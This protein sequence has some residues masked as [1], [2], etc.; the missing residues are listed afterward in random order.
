MNRAAR[1]VGIILGCL[2]AATIIGYAYYKTKNLILGPTITITNPQNNAS[3]TESLVHLKGIIKN[4]TEVSVNNRKV[5]ISEKGELD[6]KLLLLPGYNII[7]INAK[8]RFGHSTSQTI[9]S[10]FVETKT[11]SSS[12]PL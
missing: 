7:T 2:F 5:Y 12:S 9:Q 1:T 6:E 11:A 10:V 4:S 3:T 8:D